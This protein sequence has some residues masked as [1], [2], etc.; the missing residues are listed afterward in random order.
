MGVGLMPAVFSR[1]PA[2]LTDRSSLHNKSVESGIISCATLAEFYP[3]SS[4][5]GHKELLSYKSVPLFAVLCA[6][7]LWLF[8]EF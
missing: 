7:C 6:D 8:H 2:A 3:D 1:L 5:E 4:F